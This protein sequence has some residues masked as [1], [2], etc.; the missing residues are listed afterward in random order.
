MNFMA[1]L[2]QHAPNLAILS[3]VK[4][5]LE[6]GAELVLTPD[7]EPLC[8]HFAFCQPHA[9][10]EPLEQFRGWHTRN[11]HKILLLNAITRMRQK[12]RE[13]AI[14]GEQNEPFA[15]A[16]EPSH[17]KQPTVVWHQV[18]DSW[19]AG[20]VEVGR[21]H[22]DRLVQEIDDAPRIGQ[23][24]TIDANFLGPRIN[25]GAERGDHLT[26]HLNTATG[27]EFLTRTSA[28]KTGSREHLLKPLEAAIGLRL[29]R[30]W[31]RA[32]WTARPTRTRFPAGGRTGARLVWGWHNGKR[33]GNGSSR[34]LTHLP[35]ICAAYSADRAA[36]SH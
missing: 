12:V 32:P 29:A 7:R 34:D 30:P 8:M 15:H 24:L 35:A 5:H 6:D 36:G 16:I 19:S 31:G 18:D 26:V 1:E 21:H 17:G 3:L 14:I 13:V 25:L 9:L 10:P 4:N 27:D 28:A 33:G 22:T 11:L 23:P 20:R 2:G